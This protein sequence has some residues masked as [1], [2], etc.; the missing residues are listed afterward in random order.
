[1]FGNVRTMTLALLIVLI[2]LLNWL[3]NRSALAASVPVLSSKPAQTAAFTAFGSLSV[4]DARPVVLGVGGPVVEVLVQAGDTVEADQ[5][6]LR[7]DTTQ[8]DWEVQRAEINLELARIAL[9]EVGAESSESAL[10]VAQANL[11]LAQ[12]NL[13]QLEAGGV[14]EEELAAAQASASAAW[15][16]HNELQA[17][18]SEAQLRLL[19]ANLEKAQVAVTQAQ[20]DYDGVKWREDVGRTPQAAALQ[21]ATIDFNVAQA[22][23]DESTAPATVSQLQRALADAYRAQHALNELQKG[24]STADLAVARARVAAAEAALQQVQEMQGSGNQRAA[25]LRVNG[26]LIALE[27]AQRRREQ[28]EVKAP[29]AGMVL[30]LSADLGQIGSAGS[31]VAVVGDPTALELVVDV[32]QDQ[33][34]SLAVGDAVTINRV[35]SAETT[36]QGTIIRIS[37]I[38]M[39]GKGNSTFPVTVR[40]PQEGIDGF[41]PGLLVSAAF[42]G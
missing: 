23:Y 34:L 35:G 20:R 42:G 26:A 32:V 37:P 3:G 21:R 9:L 18:P 38:S 17:G 33:V 41:A 12:A 40:L 25:E 2:A 4:A 13:A 10:A 22:A 31:T 30:S 5:P 16:Y 7:L 36:V 1:M 15:A 19:G 29:V 24:V 8:L 14:T 39:P 27:E 28:A 6:L 11:E